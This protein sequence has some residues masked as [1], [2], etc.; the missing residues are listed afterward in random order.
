MKNQMGRSKWLFYPLGLAVG[1]LNG[2]FCSGGGMVAVPM[3]K[4][5][6][7]KGQQAHATSLAII[8]PLSLLSGFLYWRAGNLELGNALVYLPG[9]LLGA[10]V[11]SWLLPRLKTDW[12]RRAFGVVILFS[13]GRLL[14][15]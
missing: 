14:L 4:G 13:A 6:G 8:L 15:K 2:L 9:G 10:V 12:L 7:V 1:F 11:G 3:L 5:L